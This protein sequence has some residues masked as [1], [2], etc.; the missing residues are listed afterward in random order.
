MGA[1]T[2]LSITHI[3]NVENGYTKV[4]LPSIVSIANALSVSV[5]ELL[6]DNL[7]HVKPVFEKIIADSI[8]DCS[9]FEIKMMASAIQSFKSFIR[10]VLS[11]MNELQ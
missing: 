2:S 11:E 6:C 8:S 1:L 7:T 4:S 10:Q 3:S 9:S 5:D